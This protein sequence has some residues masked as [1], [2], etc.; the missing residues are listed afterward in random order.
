MK[1][2]LNHKHKQVFLLTAIVRDLL[3]P[4]CIGGVVSNLGLA[5][6]AAYFQEL[7]HIVPNF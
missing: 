5:R 6:H 3:Q 2:T 4:K 7:T 1:A